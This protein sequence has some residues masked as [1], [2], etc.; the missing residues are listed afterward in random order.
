M[1]QPAPVVFLLDVDNTLLDND[2]VIADL[3]RHLT[4][5]FGTESQERYWTIFE[6]RRTQ[7]GYTDYLGALQR[8]R[9]ENPRDPH[10]LQISSYLVDYPFANRLYPGSLDVI[11]HL[12]AW[13]PTVIL[14]D[15]DVIFQPRKV[16]RSG[17]AEA[18][19]GR[20]L[21]YIHKE[22][23]LD[24]VEK[25]FPARRYVLVDD[26]LRLLTAVKEVWGSR[27]TTVFPR[28]GHYA[29][30]P[31]VLTMYPPADV[32]IEH[33][34]DLLRYDL[35][36]LLAAGQPHDRRPAAES[37][38]PEEMKKS[39]QEPDLRIMVVDVGGTHVKILSTGQETPREFVSGPSMTAQEMVS[40]VL[41][42]TED[43]KYDVVSIGYPGPVLRG[44]PVAEPHNLGPGWV[45]FDF[46]AAFG[47]PVKLI[48]DAAMQ[49]LGDYE[50]GKMLF[51]GLGTGLGSAMIVDGIVESMEL[52]HLPYGKGTYEDYI[53]LRGLERVGEKRWRDYVE[54]VVARLVAALEPDYVVLGGGNVHKLNKLPPSCRA[55]ENTN[56]FRGGFRLWEK[57]KETSS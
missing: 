28:Q 40:G 27:L 25:H 18:V 43:W 54:D 2:R 29:H 50:G 49:A 38:K 22:Q 16:E 33:I 44:K 41:K 55:G 23:Q 32:T 30:D 47:C 13:G 12:S 26:K 17:L 19:E 36:A 6:E 56:A 31:T 7:L 24:D 48:N 57:L 52:G 42:A 15:G 4:Q 53:G 9:D 35:P 21:I 10:F 39:A 14:S 3:R 11:E 45:G 37:V 34:A 5:A 8:Y 20:V 51:L 46:A 1:K